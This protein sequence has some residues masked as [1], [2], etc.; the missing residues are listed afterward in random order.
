MSA[1]PSTGS[2]CNTL[3]ATGPCVIETLGTGSAPAPGGG[4]IAAGTYDLTSMVRYVGADG[5]TDMSDSRHA[6]L[7]V[8]AVIANSFSLQ[9]TEI[10]GS[11]VRRQAGVVIASGTQ[12]AFTPACPLGG[13]GGGTAGYTAT[14]T[15]FT[16]FDTSN[17]GD[18][19]LSV[20]TKR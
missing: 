12:V 2:G 8:S 20:Y 18:L 6:S 11:T 16:L 5:G 19:R 13:D 4:T 7:A 14:S 15:T 17:S 9:I 1:D 3:E 10:S